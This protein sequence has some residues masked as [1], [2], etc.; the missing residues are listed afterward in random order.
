[1]QKSKRPG[2]P[3]S[4]SYSKEKQLFFRE[5]IRF[6]SEALVAQQFQAFQEDCDPSVQFPNGLVACLYF[7]FSCLY[8]ASSACNSAT[9]CCSRAV[10]CAMIA[11]SFLG[12]LGS[13]LAAS[14]MSIGIQESLD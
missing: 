2:N 4:L 14:D 3:K 9:R 6:R 11:C 10:F 13:F 12:S 7:C 5:P 8:S 1:M